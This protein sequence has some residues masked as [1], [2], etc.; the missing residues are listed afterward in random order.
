MP[1]KLPT[2][3]GEERELRDGDRVRLRCGIDDTISQLEYGDPYV[4]VGLE[5]RTWRENG[6][7]FLDPS[8]FDIVLILG[9]AEETHENGTVSK[10]VPMRVRMEAGLWDEFTP[11]ETRSACHGETY[12]HSPK[13]AVKC[14]CNGTFHD[15]VILQP[16]PKPAPTP[17]YQERLIA[18]VQAGECVLPLKAIRLRRKDGEW[19]G[20]NDRGEYEWLWPDHALGKLPPRIEGD[21]TTIDLADVRAALEGKG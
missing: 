14:V 17:T 19:F 21:P 9:P 12:L 11:T 3:H 16:K 18:A 1:T 5:S 10:V 6:R 7:C 4:W 15:R 8:S 13:S 2:L 20:Q